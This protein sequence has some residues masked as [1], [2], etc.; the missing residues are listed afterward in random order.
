MRVVPRRG[1]RAKVFGVVVLFFAVVTWLRADEA[2]PP[3][4]DE[5]TAALAKL[6][7][8]NTNLKQQL[9]ERDAVIRKLTESLAIAR[10]ES[11]LFQ[12]KWA[13]AKLQAQ[14]LGVNFADATATAAQRQLV[15]SVRALYL[16][17]A[18][19]QRLIE[20]LQRLLT[21][22]QDDRDVAAEV[23]RTKALLAASEPAQAKT[24][25]GSTAEPT[26]HEAQ[27]LEVNPGLRLVV[28]N[29]GLVQGARVG[30]PFVVMRGDRVI[31]QVRVVEVRRRICGAVIEN[32]E[33]NA[34]VAAGDAAHVTKS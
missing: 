33:K 10:T 21:A 15:E 25:T 8:E 28:L 30:M 16:A 31:A 11:E 18:E 5:L 27:V 6:D 23:D 17:E 4:L 34:K 7:A 29:V 3:N 2:Q 26:L 24:S 12:K 22:I 13:D 9:D 19:R 20:Q 32:V 1:T 14:T